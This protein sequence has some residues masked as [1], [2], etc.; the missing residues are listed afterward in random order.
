[1]K[2]EFI[3]IQDFLLLAEL[4]NKLRGQVLQHRPS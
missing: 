1:M 4:L 2:L 3:K